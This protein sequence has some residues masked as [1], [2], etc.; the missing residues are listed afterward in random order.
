MLTAETDATQTPICFWIFDATVTAK[1]RSIYI[2][3]HD[4]S[5]PATE[6]SL[7][8]D[9][10]IKYYPF[11]DDFGPMNLSSAVAYIQRLDKAVSISKHD[12]IVYC[13]QD[14]RRSLTNAAFLIGAYL[15]LKFGEAPNYVSNRFSMIAK[16]RFEG[17]RDA[18]Y[19]NPDFR[20][21]LIDC[22]SGLHQA[23]MRR[24]LA[25]PTDQHSQVWGTINMDEYTHY[26]NPLNADLHEVVP[27]KFVAF[28]GPI[29]LPGEQE[30]LD[31]EAQGAR[32]FSPSYYVNVFLELG[33]TT[34]IRLNEPRYNRRAF[35]TAGLEH[36]DLYFAD[37]T[38]P[39]SD[40][41]TRFFA[42]VDTAPG[43]VAVHC[44]AGLGRTGTLIALY[45]MRS[46]GF[47]AREAIGWLRIVRPGSVIGRQQQYLCKVERLMHEKA[48]AR[49]GGR[50]PQSKLVARDLPS[51]RPLIK[52]PKVIGGDAVAEAAQLLAEQVAA[53]MARRGAARSQLVT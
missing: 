15:M 40:V 37:C 31:D 13:V 47:T 29:D 34:V 11:C 23:V 2:A 6:F 32:C 26:D 51:S 9:E 10:Q 1:K 3:Q 43:L 16:H 52:L 39:P 44:K 8:S 45:M 30:F 12:A 33:V 24:W 25:L 22:W 17:Y 28:K 36:Y 42:I 18:T 5:P 21:E 48:A 46:L 14:G 41:V 4:G 38:S 50:A 53:G 27:G 19:S 49:S 7:F 35:T 20:L